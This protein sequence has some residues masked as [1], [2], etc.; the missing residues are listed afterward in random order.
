M[1]KSSTSAGAMQKISG[2]Y[3]LRNKTADKS[4]RYL[5]VKPCLT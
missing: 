2:N 5:Q 4:F 3:S 1:E